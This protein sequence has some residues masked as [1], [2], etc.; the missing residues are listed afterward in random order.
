M[1]D[2][3]MCSGKGCELKSECY[4]YTAFENPH[5]Q[6]FFTTPP[7]EADGT[8]EQFWRNESCGSLFNR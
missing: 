1:A 8:C 5:R 3:T 2:I 6:S 7:V 4:R